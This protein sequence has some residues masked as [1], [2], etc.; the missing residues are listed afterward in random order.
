MR[1]ITA[2]L[3]AAVCS[4]QMPMARA[5]DVTTQIAPQAGR[6]ASL[7]TITVPQGTTVP[8]TLVGPIRNKMRPGDTV[9]AQVAF[10]I[11]VGTQ[12]AIPAGTYVQGTLTALHPQGK[13]G[14][15]ATVELHMTGLLFANGYA[16]PLDADNMQ[17][18]AIEPEP[19]RQET[20]ELADARDG[21]PVLGEGF[22]EGQFPSPPPPTLPPTPHV[23]PNPAI[24][25]GAIAGGTALALVLALTLGRH[26]MANTDYVVFDSGWQFQMVLQQPL[27]LDASRVADAVSAAPAR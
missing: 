24:V 8:L 10:P 16:V 15:P 17:A 5:Q 6:A 7:T 21:A 14:Q 25:I 23:G 3:I 18:L 11:T 2:V 22:G 19:G 26:N 4:A 1:W 20:V 27:T 13:R 9:R 12:L